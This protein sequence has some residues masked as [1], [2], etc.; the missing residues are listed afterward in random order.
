[1]T[2]IQ[3]KVPNKMITKNKTNRIQRLKKYK[4]PHDLLKQK[5]KKKSQT[6]FLNVGT[7]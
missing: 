1:M 6:T 7:V 3:L 2:H 4:N 5:T